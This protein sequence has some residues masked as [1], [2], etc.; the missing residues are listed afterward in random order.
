MPMRHKV[1]R[2]VRRAF[3]PTP[4][5][6]A[7]GIFLLPGSRSGVVPMAVVVGHIIVLNILSSTYAANRLR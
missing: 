1:S 3:R 4:L 6:L 5:W 2:L 7:L